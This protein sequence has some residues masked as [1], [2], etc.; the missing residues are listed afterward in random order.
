MAFYPFSPST[1]DHTPFF[2]KAYTIPE[3]ER[4]IVNTNPA[5]IVKQ[6]RTAITNALGGEEGLLDILNDTISDRQVIDGEGILG[7][8]VVH[9][10]LRVLDESGNEVLS[11]SRDVQKPLFVG[12]T[13]KSQF[14]KDILS[15]VNTYS[16]QNVGKVSSGYKRSSIFELRKLELTLQKV[17]KAT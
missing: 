3:D 15:F 1:E 13:S 17:E 7:A 16:T 12:V 5:A 14:V 2:K 10:R 8:L 6:Q 11:E 4:F 9:G